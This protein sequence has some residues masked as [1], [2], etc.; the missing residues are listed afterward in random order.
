MGY[1]A[2]AAR[3][4]TRFQAVAFREGVLHPRGGST[5]NNPA[6]VRAFEQGQEWARGHGGRSQ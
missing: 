2:Q 4:L 3:F 6:L 5:E 1:Y